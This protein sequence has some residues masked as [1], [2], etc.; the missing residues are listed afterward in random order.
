M[1]HRSVAASAANLP[2]KVR[3]LCPTAATAI[4]SDVTGSGAQADLPRLLFLPGPVPPVL[5]GRDQV[6]P[7]TFS[8]QHR[9]RDRPAAAAA[10]PLPYL[11]IMAGKGGN[12]WVI[13][14]LKLP[15]PAEDRR[16]SFHDGRPEMPQTGH[17][18][19]SRSVDASCRHRALPSSD[20]SARISVRWRTYGSLKHRTAHLPSLYQSRSLSAS[21]SP[22]ACTAPI[23]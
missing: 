1:A 21:P 12:Y 14:A 22:R 19:T 11:C 16:T 2:Q 5:S 9:I 23:G 8:A 10:L 13:Y 3:S 7:R 18:T 17:C 15:L 20:C 6:P 4:C